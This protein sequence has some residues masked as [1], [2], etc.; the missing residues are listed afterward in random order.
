MLADVGHLSYHAQCVV[1]HILRMTRGKADAHLWRFLSHAAQQLWECRSVVSM[2]AVHILSQQRHLLEA[3]VAQ[4]AHL[5]EDTLHIAAT[6]AT[7]GVGHDAVV[8]EVVASTHD[9]HKTADLRTVQAL[10]HH[11]TVSL[12]CRQ[13]NIHGLM[14]QLSLCY[15]VGQRHIGVW[16]SHQVAVVVLQQVILHALSHTAQYA[17]DEA[18]SFWPFSL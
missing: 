6:L 2:I 18:V 16:T 7:T 17:D 15:Q 9:A 1:A 13:F 11:V 8:A 5:S 3:T 10:W 4:V 14:S 12:R